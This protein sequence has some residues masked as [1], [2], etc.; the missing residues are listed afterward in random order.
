MKK[1]LRPFRWLFDR[2]IALLIIL[3]LL[4]ERGRLVVLT[5]VLF[6][7]LGLLIWSASPGDANTVD[8]IDTAAVFLVLGVIAAR[9]L[10]HFLVIRERSVARQVEERLAAT[11]AGID[12][13]FKALGERLG[14]VESAMNELALRRAFGAGG[15]GKKP[16]G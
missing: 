11:T 6:V 2:L 9:G 7:A 14:R 10:E 13:N 3:R 16:G 8:S 15:P 5:A 1:L 12:A 4:D